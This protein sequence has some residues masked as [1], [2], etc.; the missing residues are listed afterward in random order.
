MFPAV[1][2]TSPGRTGDKNEPPERTKERN[3]QNKKKKRR[4]SAQ[5]GVETVS[6]LSNS[7]LLVLSISMGISIFGW[8]TKNT[9]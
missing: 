7:L 1:I 3:K 4:G 6:R 2:M 9:D 8:R 5:G